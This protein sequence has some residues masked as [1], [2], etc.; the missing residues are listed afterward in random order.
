[1]F[2]SEFSEC[3]PEPLRVSKTLSE[4]TW[5]QTIFINSIDVI[6]IVYPHS[7]TSMQWSFPEATWC[8]ASQETMQK[9]RYEN[10]S[11]S[12]PDKRKVAKN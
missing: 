9:D 2:T 12:K 11:S 10:L 7:L 1:M 3:G 5:S 8:M 4:G 6:F